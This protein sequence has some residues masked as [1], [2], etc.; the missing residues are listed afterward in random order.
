MTSSDDSRRNLALGKRI[1]AARLRR[2]GNAPEADRLDAD[3]AKLEAEADDQGGLRL[4]ATTEE[5]EHPMTTIESMARAICAADT[6][7]PAPEA[8]IQW[9]DKRVQAW[10][11]RQPMAEAALR[12][13]LTGPVGYLLRQA[14]E[15]V[16]GGHAT[17]MPLGWAVHALPSDITDMLEE[18]S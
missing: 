6:T 2:N 16:H 10:E 8:P 4:C 18:K 14:C 9:R 3:A 1:L 11:A 17:Y 5:T 15:S 7:A 12:A 13:L